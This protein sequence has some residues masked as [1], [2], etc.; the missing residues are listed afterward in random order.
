MVFLEQ[1][2]VAVDGDDDRGWQIRRS[3]LY[4]RP[5]GQVKLHLP[6]SQLGSLHHHQHQLC[7]GSFGPGDLEV[8]N[9]V[10]LNLGY[11]DTGN[12][13]R[14]GHPARKVMMPKINK[15]GHFFWV[16]ASPLSAQPPIGRR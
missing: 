15:E 11:I 7:F 16:H 1:P 13:V 10:E 14:I 4:L 2:E 5:S 12:I 8:V 6:H 3:G 9:A